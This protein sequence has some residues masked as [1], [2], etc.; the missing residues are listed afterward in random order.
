[1]ETFKLSTP[2]LKKR[3]LGAKFKIYHKINIRSGLYKF[4]G[5]NFIKLLLA[6]I[7]IVILLFAIDLVFDLKAQQ[8]RFKEFVDKLEPTYVFVLFFASES[9]LGLIPPDLFMVWGKA[10][11]PETPYL[12]VFILATISYIGGIVA[13]KLGVLIRKM[14]RVKK[15]AETKYEKNF[16]LIEKWGGLVIVM[17]A[18]FPLPYALT[19]TV[20][21]IVK[22]PFKP[23][24]LYGLTRFIRFFLYAVVIFGAL[25]EFL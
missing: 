8:A 19:S 17:A 10:R 18:L 3:T 22:Y 20:A 2:I 25:K 15:I 9:L 5:K 4:L 1:M 24:L 6:L 11:F 7:G 12:L 23:F 16:E 21:G 13:Y 14:P